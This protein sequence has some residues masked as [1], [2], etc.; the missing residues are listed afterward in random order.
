M[1]NQEKDDEKTRSLFVGE[2]DE[3]DLLEVQT[4]FEKAMRITIDK[5]KCDR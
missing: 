1:P 4:T 2:L 5:V 3:Q